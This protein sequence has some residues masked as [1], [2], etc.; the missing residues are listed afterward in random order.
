MTHDSQDFAVKVKGIF[1]FAH[2]RFVPAQHTSRVNDMWN[3]HK[4]LFSEF[5]N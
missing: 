4:T 3:R 5:H 1:V 2:K